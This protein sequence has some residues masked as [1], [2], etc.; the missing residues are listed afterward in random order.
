MRTVEKL[1]ESVFLTS[2]GAKYT[3]FQGFEHADFVNLI[4]PL[5]APGPSW[6]DFGR[7][8]AFQSRLWEAPGGSREKGF[9]L[10]RAPGGVQNVKNTILEPLS[11]YPKRSGP[12]KYDGFTVF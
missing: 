11:F 3:Y 2:L 7:P 12:Y 4:W 8:S 9:V 1:S 5:E 6:E 10:C